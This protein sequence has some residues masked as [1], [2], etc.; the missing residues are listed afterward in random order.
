[1][2]VTQSAQ[3][4]MFLLEALVA[5]VVFSL[6]MLGLAGVLGHALRES[7]SARWRGEA[8]ELASSTLGRMW[9]EDAATL[10]SRY[11]ARADGAAYRALLAAALRLPGVTSDQ[12]APVVTIT[13]EALGRRR[14]RV[15]VYWQLPGDSRV[16]EASA[17]ALLPGS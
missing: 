9:V 15:T 14:V 3:R 16:H 11:D 5:L 4:G 8:F 2:R 13:D 1:M 7:G 10:A 17:G 12:N 6:A